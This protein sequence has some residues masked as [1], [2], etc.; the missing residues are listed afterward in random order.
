M[1][2]DDQEEYS[3]FMYKANSLVSD[4][5]PDKVLLVMANFTQVGLAMLSICVCPLQICSTSSHFSHLV[6]YLLMITWNRSASCHLDCEI[7]LGR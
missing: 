2:Y 4:T 5:Q 7:V 3:Y 6:T 1:E